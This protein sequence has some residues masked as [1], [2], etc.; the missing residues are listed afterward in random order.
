MQ[1]DFECP[2]GEIGVNAPNGPIG[3]GGGGQRRLLSHSSWDEEELSKLAT[4]LQLRME[5]LL[6]NAHAPPSELNMHIPEW[7]DDDDVNELWE[8][9]N[10]QEEIDLTSLFEKISRRT[11]QQANTNFTYESAS[12]W[13]N[14]TFNGTYVSN[15]SQTDLQPL[16]I[17]D[18]ILEDGREWDWNN[19]SNKRC[20]CGWPNSTAG[21]LVSLCL[22]ERVGEC[23]FCSTPPSL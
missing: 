4:D 10:A 5:S 1:G 7:L 6:Q 3:A 23:F 20:G 19:Y 17:C 21:L 18:L 12:N 11:V 8:S 2:D 16:Q 9:F 14:V 13:T 15:I 22:E